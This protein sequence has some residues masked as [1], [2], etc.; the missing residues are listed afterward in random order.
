M[1]ISSE[2]SELCT[3]F[4]YSGIKTIVHT[5]VYYVLLLIVELRIMIKYFE[6]VFTQITF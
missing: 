4:K 1:I 2:C 6:L 3:Y 5:Y